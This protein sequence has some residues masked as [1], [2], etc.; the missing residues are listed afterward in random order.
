MNRWSI[1]TRITMKYP[2]IFGGF[3]VT[4]LCIGAFIF[5]AVANVRAAIKAFRSGVFETAIWNVE[6]QQKPFLFLLHIVIA[7]SFALFFLTLAA[8]VGY[9]TVKRALAA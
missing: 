5:G 3:P 8:I 7:S 6:K 4:I 9:I 2:V 1:E